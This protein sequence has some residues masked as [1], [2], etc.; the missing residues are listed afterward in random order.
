MTEQSPDRGDLFAALHDADLA[1]LDYALNIESHAGRDD[2]WTAVA[3]AFVDLASCK[4]I[5]PPP[6]DINDE[7]TAHLLY[8]LIRLEDQRRIRLLYAANETGNQS[9]NEA[10]IHE[11]FTSPSFFEREPG[12]T[13]DDLIRWPAKQE[14]W[15]DEWPAPERVAFQCQD[16]L[17]RPL[18]GP[19]TDPWGEVEPGSAS[20][21]MIVESRFIDQAMAAAEAL[22][23]SDDTRHRATTAMALHRAD[24]ATQLL[25][26]EDIEGDARSAAQ[27]LAEEAL[28]ELADTSGHE[29]TVRKAWLALELSETE[30][31]IANFERLVDHSNPHVANTARYYIVKLAWHE[32]WWDIAA[33]ASPEMIDDPASLRSAYAYFAAT[34]HRHDG[35]RDSF[36]GLAREALSDRS[37]SADDPFLGALYRQTLRELARYEIDERTDE[38]LEEFGP[39]A[40]LAQRQREFAGVALDMGHPETADEIAVSLISQTQDA[41]ALPRL[42][43]IVALAAFMADD[44]I[45]FN[46]YMERLLHRP[47]ELR[48]AIPS[49]RRAAFFAHQDTE[50][51]GVLYTMLPMMAEW[52]EEPATEAMRQRWLETI[53]EHTQ[54]F[55][56]RA[57]DS[58]VS[59][60]LTELYQLTGQLLAEHPRGYAGRVGSEVDESSTLVLGTVDMPPTPPLD[61]APRPQLRWPP[62]YS[63]LLIPD[64]HIPP[65]SFRSSLDAPNA[66]AEQGATR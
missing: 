43:A 35:R 22:E 6:D 2:A 58:A 24:L 10:T 12:P 5:A 25:Q 53:V 63:L 23:P 42:Y 16:L 7:P 55:L 45:K 3:R 28:D 1:A 11:V 48:Q 37:R 60:N 32:G 36:L 39:R 9:W 61:E 33:D 38:L 40:E 49:T 52:G 18:P 4:E 66:G 30:R 64:D 54:D 31:S 46:A 51:A 41:R 56:R 29:A 20:G 44:E 13:D 65:S 57:P 15:P 14:A 59:D 21:Q 34:A 47:D 50:L 62:V 27:A 8:E 17:R 19:F 26:R